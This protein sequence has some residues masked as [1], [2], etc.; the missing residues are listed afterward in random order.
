MDPKT[1]LC[2]SLLSLDSTREEC[3]GASGGSGNSVSGG[4]GSA[5]AAFSSRNFKPGEL[6]FFRAF[7]G[8]V[9]CEPCQSKF[10]CSQSFFPSNLDRK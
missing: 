7:R 2:N 8:G 6:F 3:C 4:S 9:P 5:F 10:C 1:G